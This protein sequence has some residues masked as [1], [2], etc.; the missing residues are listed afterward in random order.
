MAGGASSGRSRS[1]G[2]WAAY[3]ACALALLYAAVSFYWA[4]GAP[5]ASAPLGGE[6]EALGRARDLGLIALVWVTGVLKVMAGLL[7]LVRPWARTLPR[8]A[9]LAAAWG[10]ALLLTLYGGAL[11]A[12]Q[13]LV[14]GGIITPPGPVDWRALRWHLFLWDSWFLVWGL[15]LGVAACYHRHEASWRPPVSGFPDSS[16]AGRGCQWAYPGKKVGEELLR[17]GERGEVSGVLDKG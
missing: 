3:A 7:A 2:V 13:A 6:L 16:G 8:R 9:M 1:G 14:V 4:A 15:L 5:R 11:V 17:L 12:G 10:G